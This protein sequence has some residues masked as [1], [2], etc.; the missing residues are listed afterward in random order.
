MHGKLLLLHKSYGTFI[1]GQP[2]KSLEQQ[3][4]YGSYATRTLAVHPGIRHLNV[5]LAP[6][7]GIGEEL[8]A[9]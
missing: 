4:F 6:F 5:S 8:K 9:L 3:R 1:E 7:D 2:F